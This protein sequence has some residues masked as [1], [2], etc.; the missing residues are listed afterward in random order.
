MS[1]LKLL[2]PDGEIE[3]NG[4]PVTIAALPFEIV[5]EFADAINAIMD[6]LAEGKLG[7]TLKAAYS[8]IVKLLNRCVF[9]EEK[10]KKVP[11]GQIPM[12]V[13]PQILREVANRSLG[14]GEWQALGGEL[15]AAAGIVPTAPSQS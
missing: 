15:R 7:S 3:I 11:I 14:L 1:K 6:S 2:C 13:L 9:L 10:G 4:V 8:D 5:P 12:P